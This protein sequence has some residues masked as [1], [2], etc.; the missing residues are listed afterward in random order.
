MYISHKG[1]YLFFEGMEMVIQRVVR[2]IVGIVRGTVIQV[3]VRTF[4]V[5]VI[6]TSLSLDVRSRRAI[7]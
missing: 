6:V 4:V 1:C 7:S 3:V 5:R 2:F